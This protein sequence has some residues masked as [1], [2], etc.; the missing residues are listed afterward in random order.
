LDLEQYKEYS[1]IFLSTT[2]ALQ[3]G[4]SFAATVALI[5]HTA[6]YHGKDLWA[7]LFNSNSEP[8]DI[9]NKLI[10]K[11]PP[12]P[13]WWFMTLMACMMTIGLVTCL[14]WESQLPWW[15]Y[16]LAIALAAF[17]LVLSL[18]VCRSISTAD[19][20]TDSN[21]SNRCHICTFGPLQL[22]FSPE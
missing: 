6:L 4:L 11:Y 19:G 2:F 8:K 17:F 5:T 7:R 13:V 14:V 10:E 18:I 16:F 15:G 22:S 9:H 1:P 21:W 3:Y 20:A 12:V